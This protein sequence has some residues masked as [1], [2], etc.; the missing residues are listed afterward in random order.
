MFFTLSEVQLLKKFNEFIA[1]M[2]KM[3]D[4]HAEMIGFPF[5]KSK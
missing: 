4:E 5:K 1:E 3:L 2:Y